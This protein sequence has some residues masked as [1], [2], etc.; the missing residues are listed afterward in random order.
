MSDIDMD[1]HVW[2]GWRVRDFIGEL[3]PQLDYIME[4][5]RWRKPFES[6]DDMYKWIRENQPYYK[7]DIPEVKEYFRRRYYGERR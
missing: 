6:I 7:R 1:R 3:Q 4:D 5:R 2:E